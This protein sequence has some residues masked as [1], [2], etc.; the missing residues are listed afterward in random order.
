MENKLSLTSAIELLKKDEIS[1]KDLVSS[2]IA[3]IKKWDKQINAFVTLNK[4]AFDEAGKIKG[5]PTHQKPLLGIPVAIKDNFLTKNLRTTAS[6][7]VLDDYIPVY[8]S[9]VV[10]RLKDA[11]A[12]ILGKTNMDAWAHGSSTETSDFGPT[13]NPWDTSRLP[14]GSE[15]K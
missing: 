3:Q 8:D 1:S 12:I 10:K 4:N 5:V 2:C 7:K 6:S 11:G 9:T 14:G 15:P 13:K